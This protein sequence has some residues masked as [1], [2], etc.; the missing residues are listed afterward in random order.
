[1]PEAGLRFH[2]FGEYFFSFGYVKRLLIFLPA[3]DEW[4]NHMLT[5]AGLSYPDTLRAR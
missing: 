2:S 3:S 1:L 5:N 4:A